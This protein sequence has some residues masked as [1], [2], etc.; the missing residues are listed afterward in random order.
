MEQFKS[1]LSEATKILTEL[2]EAW[3]NLDGKDYHEVN[4]N[5]TLH[6]NFEEVM[7]DFIEW[8]SNLNKQ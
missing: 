8:Q 6:K 1:K 7:K 5:Y 4:E 3:D 2:S